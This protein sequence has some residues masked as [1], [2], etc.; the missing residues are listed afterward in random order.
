MSVHAFSSATG[1]CA[2]RNC[3]FYAGPH[4]KGKITNGLLATGGLS[5]TFG[6]MTLSTLATTTFFTVGKATPLT[7]SSTKTCTGIVMRLSEVRGVQTNTTLS[8]TDTVQVTKLCTTV[9][10]GGICQT[11]RSNTTSVTTSF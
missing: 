8:G 6:G 5:V 4:L 7:I 10:V 2:A 9:G 3:A 1:G 11:S